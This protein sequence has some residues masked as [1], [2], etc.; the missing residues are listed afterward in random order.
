[1]KLSFV[2]KT[3][4]CV[5]PLL[6]EGCAPPPV[7]SVNNPAVETY[8][9]PTPVYYSTPTPVVVTP[10]PVYIAP[11]RHHHHHITRHRVIHRPIV[12]HRRVVH[13]KHKRH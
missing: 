2:V 10:A 13:R 1:M 12:V 6:L 5:M 9:A 7:R 11:R 3:A 8:S 4:L